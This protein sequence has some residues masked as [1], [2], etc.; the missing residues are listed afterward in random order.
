M[1]PADLLDPSATI[2]APPPGAVN[3]RVGRAVEGP[4]GRWVPCA[5]AIPGG[6]FVPGLFQV[7][8]GRHQV[9]RLDLPLASA[10]EALVRAVDLATAAAA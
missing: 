3:V 6:R 7:G 8:P 10:N 2:S 1:T 5:T 4:G 9:C